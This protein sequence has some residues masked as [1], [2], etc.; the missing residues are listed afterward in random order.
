MRDEKETGPPQQE[1][2]EVRITNQLTGGEKCA[3]PEKFSLIPPRPMAEVA[4]VYGYG[5]GKYAP[6]NWERGYEWSLSIDAGERHWNHF[7]EG[8]DRDSDSGLHPLAHVVFHCLALMEWERTHPELDDRQAPSDTPRVPSVLPEYVTFDNPHVKPVFPA[9]LG[10]RR[11]RR[12]NEY[13]YLCSNCR[14]GQNLHTDGI[15]GCHWRDG[16]VGCTCAMFSFK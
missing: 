2:G 11:I 14:H 4:R 3:K 12:T 1:P 6:R 15:D 5:A 7:K 8:L 13:E 10:S 9:E 16:T